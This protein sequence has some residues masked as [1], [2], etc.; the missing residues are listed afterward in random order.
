MGKAQAHESLRPSH[1]VS[2][3]PAWLS[4]QSPI[5]QT[6]EAQARAWLSLPKPSQNS[7]RTAGLE[8][9]LTPVSLRTG[10]FKHRVAFETLTDLCFREG[11]ATLWISRQQKPHSQ[12]QR[13]YA[14]Y[15]EGERA[16]MSNASNPA[17]VGACVFEDRDSKSLTWSRWQVEKETE[18]RWQTSTEHEEKTSQV[19]GFQSP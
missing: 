14:C 7:W 15:R 19:V 9:P 16:G 1:H 3:L 12:L 4:M 18:E 13:T 11:Y 2:S 8:V 5:E 17:T 10:K 6:Q